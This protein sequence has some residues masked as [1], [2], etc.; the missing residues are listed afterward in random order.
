MTSAFSTFDYPYT[1]TKYDIVEGYY[2]TSGVWVPQ[3]SSSTTFKGHL[4]A[5]SEKE[6]RFLPEAVKEAGVMNLAV[7]A[8]AVTLNNGDKITITEYG[9]ATSNWY[10]VREV[11]STSV[12]TQFGINRRQFYISLVKS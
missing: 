12:M 3:T 8:A 5:V 6:L 9:G 1:L 11:G 7:E 10:V 2:N 4:S